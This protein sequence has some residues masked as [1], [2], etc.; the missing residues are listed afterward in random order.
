MDGGGARADEGNL[1]RSVPLFAGLSAAEAEELCRSAGRVFLDPGDRLLEEGAPGD[2]LYIIVSGEFEVTKRAGGHDVVLATRKAGEYI[3][4]MSL[5][6]RA[7]RSASVR[8]ATRGEVLKVGPDAL[9]RLLVSHPEAATSLLR[10]VAGRLRST[11]SSLVQADKLAALGTLAAGLAHELNNPAAAIQRSV[12]YLS[13]AHDVLRRSA[14]GLAR[15]SLAPAE[16]ERLDALEAD[17]AGLADAAPASAT[18]QHESAL[19]SLLEEWGVADPWEVATAMARLGWLPERLREIA[20]QF[21]P[22]VARGVVQWLGAAVMAAQVAAEIRQA[23]LAISRIVGAVRSY[24]YLDR[25]PVQDVDVV[26]SLED[27]LVILNHKIR[28][29]VTITRDFAPDLPRIEAHAGELNQVWTNI[30]DNAIQAMGGH[31]TISLATRGLGAE[32]EVRIEDTGPGMTADVAGRVFE[33]FFTTKP[34]GEGTGLGLHV[35]HNIVVNRH[36]GRITF[37]TRPGRTAFRIVLPRKLVA[38]G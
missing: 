25:A 13:E 15:L 1:I 23:S 34:Q 19:A 35:A 11:E 2:A 20:N 18:S 7:P 8:A 21:R 3:G 9:Q 28:H 17:I 30:I 10:T 36:H 24:S 27:T 14:V 12:D 26:R 38:P 22:E 5:I 33:P 32:V 16:T 4:E 37:E 6:E 29:G 31:G